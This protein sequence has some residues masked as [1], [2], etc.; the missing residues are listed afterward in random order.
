MARFVVLDH[1]LTR[2]GG[3]HYEQATLILRTADAIGH[4]SVLVTNRLFSQQHLLPS[5]WQV[6]ALFPDESFDCQADYPLDVNGASLTCPATGASVAAGSRPGTWWRQQRQ[7]W[8]AWQLRRR[9]GRFAD[10]CRK[11]D[12]AI[13][14]RDGDHVFIPTTSLF[15]LLGLVQ[16]LQSR[17]TSVDVVWHVCFHYGFLQGREPDY[18]DQWEQQARI[19][20]QLQYLVASVP[21]GR[22]KCYATTDKLAHQFNRLAVTHFEVLPFPVDHRALER[23]LAVHKRQPLRLTCAGFLRREKGKIWA[24][25]M[26][27][28]LWDRELAPGHVQLVV[29]TN[30]RQARR[31]L[32]RGTLAAPQFRSSIQGVGKDPLVWLRH[33]LTR[34]AYLDLIRESD[35]ALFL[36][37]GSAY[38]TRCSGVLVEMLAAGVP[39]LVPAGSWLAEQVADPISAHLDHLE[40]QATSLCAGAPSQIGWRSGPTASAAPATSAALEIGGDTQEATCDISVP[41]SAAALLVSLQWHRERRV[42][43]YLRLCTDQFDRV[44]SPIGPATATILS[45]RPTSDHVLALIPLQPGVCQV[46]LR[47]QNAFDNAPIV[48]GHTKISCLPRREGQQTSYPAGSVGLVFADVEQ[49]PALVRNMNEHY[50]HY[51][52]TA[53]EFAH[54]WRHRHD[55]Q[56]IVATLLRNSQALRAAA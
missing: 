50:D 26:V 36:H 30:Q 44:A 25:R 10:A 31:M 39:V 24:S 12:R 49:L 13:Q 33:P 8:T 47:L 15:D 27:Q 11:M 32:P 5:H 43:T 19:G 22:L 37:D 1:S 40:K 3:H 14:L 42:G 51:R 6:L 9:I 18:A 21:Q 54:Q 52:R 46:R 4:D 23:P 41:N 53:S 55:A 17:G 7:R 29:Q 45:P 48:I 35:I 56:Q 38:Y 28:Q 16:F 20:R 2:V 34:D